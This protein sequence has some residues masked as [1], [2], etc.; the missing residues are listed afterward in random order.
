MF[1]D[2][3]ANATDEFPEDAIVDGHRYV[4]S[5]GVCLIISSF[6]TGLSVLL[7][8]TIVMQHN[9]ELITQSTLTT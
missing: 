7:D 3:N 5:S 4:P 9:H 1:Q 2:A 6:F 8:A